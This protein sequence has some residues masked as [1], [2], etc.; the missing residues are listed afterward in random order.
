MALL[1]PKPDP[2]I[3]DPEDQLPLVQEFPKM[4][5]HADI[6]ARIVATADEETALLAADGWSDVPVESEPKT[7]E[8]PPEPPPDPG[9]GFA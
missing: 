7:P 9:D 3:V 2:E 5:Y 4:L 6:G 1:R 8:P